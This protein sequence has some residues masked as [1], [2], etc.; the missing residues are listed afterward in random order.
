MK[1]YRQLFANVLEQ[2]WYTKSGLTLF[3]RP[4][5]WAYICIVI[6]RRVMYRLSILKATRLPVPVI[7]VGNITVGGTGKTPLVIWLA[8]Y[9]KQAGFKPGIIS[10]GYAGNARHWPQQVRPDADP[11]MVGDEALVIARRTRCPMAVGPDRV[12]AAHALL[13][14]AC[15]DVIISDDGLQ[16]Y[17]MERTIE[18]AVI[19][20]VRRLGNGFCLPAGP[21][22]ECKSR[23]QHVDFIVTNGSAVQDEYAMRYV[24]DTAINLANREEKSL[25][26]F[27]SAQVTAIAGIGNPD[28]FFNYLRVHGIRLV[29]KAF[30]DHH[31][32]QHEELN[33]PELDVL[34]MTEKDAV[35]CERFAQSNWWYVPISVDLPSEF[36][37]KV[38]SLMESRHGQKDT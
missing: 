21:L 14:H 35:K 26:E 30:P 16:H 24:G 18:I 23:L 1:T 12:A 20:G 2:S 13:K 3:L 28:R 37:M 25:S 4:I 34:L 10:R 17:A 27:K 9:L 32:F 38:L 7:I 29:S 6:I 5:S 33:Y 15:I 22:R 31:K 36:G 11:V 19:D 8:N